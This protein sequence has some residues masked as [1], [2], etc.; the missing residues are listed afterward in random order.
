[1]NR[2]DIDPHLLEPSD[3]GP[4]SEARERFIHGLLESLH[5][6]TSAE[7]DRRVNA[8][9][10]R[11]EA[12]IPLHSHGRIRR[13]PLLSSMAAAVALVFLVMLGWPTDRTALA[14]VQQSIA[15]SQT[16]GD[17]HYEISVTPPEG[18]DLH[19]IAALDVRD[20]SHYLVTATSPEG[21]TVTLGR[22]GDD[23]WA[24]HPD[25]TLERYAPKRLLPPWINFGTSTVMLVSVDDLLATLERSYDLRRTENAPIPGTQVLCERVTAM[26]KGG[27]P[28]PNRVELW[29]DRDS[30][31]VRRMELHW[32][33]RPRPH[34]DDGPP[35][36]RSGP[37]GDG[38]PRG[39]PDPLEDARFVADNGLP[40]PP[41][42]R[43]GP[44]RRAAPQPEDDD[45]ASPRDEGRRPGAPPGV[46]EG[47][48]PEGRPRGPRPEFLDGPPDF[49]RHP[50]PPKML[51]FQLS[52]T[53]AF[54]EGWFT[55]AS[56]QAR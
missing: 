24:I 38:P 56:H 27:T 30:H 35:R 49:D 39:R 15:A 11:L 50:P 40:F 7:T 6:D 3:P 18:D 12:P 51:V 54:P 13:W 33:A 5:R 21:D 42:D 25:G 43:I 34:R 14:T 28:D 10:A 19:Q 46:E 9:M 2:P 44:G 48:S 32:T 16:A 41:P 4:Q 37:R 8:L 22:S 23:S 47:R 36:Q 45:G 1:M 55:P 31:I 26:H 17:R 29:I 20:P 52:G 53:S